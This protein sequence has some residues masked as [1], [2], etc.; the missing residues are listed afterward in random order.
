MPV[1]HVNQGY[2]NNIFLFVI[3]KNKLEITNQLWSQ[4]NMLG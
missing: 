2:E 4:K 1:L 3:K